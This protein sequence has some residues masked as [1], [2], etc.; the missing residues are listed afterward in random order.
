MV[1]IPEHIQY[2]LKLTQTAA[3]RG[4][5]AGSMSLRTRR[6]STPCLQRSSF[7]SAITQTYVTRGFCLL[8]HIPVLWV[9]KGR[10]SRSNGRRKH[11]QRQSS[12]SIYC[13][14]VSLISSAM[15]STAVFIIC[16]CT[17]WIKKERNQLGLAYRFFFSY[18]R[19]ECFSHRSFFNK[20]MI[21][22]PNIKSFSTLSV[23]LFYVY[24]LNSILC[25]QKS[26]SR[27]ARCFLLVAENAFTASSQYVLTAQKEKRGWRVF[28]FLFVPR[29]GAQFC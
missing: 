18:T 10:W 4:Q 20:C 25:S 13:V 2:S 11:K 29:V 12:R 22:T 23:R 6:R 17:A 19:T 28:L 5:P 7:L 14:S 8:L 21:Q 26:M 1:Q 27:R 15:C 3:W 16:Y 9:R 24:M